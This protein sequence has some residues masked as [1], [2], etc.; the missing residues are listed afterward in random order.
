ME[1]LLQPDLNIR[2]GALS[3]GP[4]EA[5]VD[6]RRTRWAATT[7]PGAVNRWRADKPDL[8]LDAWVEERFP[9]LRRGYIKRVL[10]SYNTYQLLYGRAPKLPVIKSASR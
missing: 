7:G 3:R 2:M 9:S 4:A 8:P 1:Q 5:S 10:R 6:T